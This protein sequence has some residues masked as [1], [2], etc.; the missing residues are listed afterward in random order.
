ML[1]WLISALFV[2]LAVREI[3]QAHVPRSGY[4]SPDTAV[5]IPYLCVMLFLAAVFAYTPLRYARFENLLTRK[6]RIL[7]ESPIA[8]V[9]CNTL[10]DTFFDS[11]VFTAGHA[12]FETG[13]IVFQHPWCGRLM[14][15]LSKPA[16]ATQVEIDSL[17]ILVH[18]SMHIRGERNEASADCQAIQ[19]EYRASRL[20]GIPEPVARINS[21]AYYLGE[22]QQR[23]TQGGYSS[24]YFSDQCAPGKALDEKLPDTTWN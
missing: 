1:W 3:Y 16:G 18:E 14:D 12:N 13:E 23:A 9:H 11:N 10:F 19:R 15:Y 5:S 22:Y 21:K 7:S 8:R 6:A 24:Q 20:M 2:A 4:A 17:H